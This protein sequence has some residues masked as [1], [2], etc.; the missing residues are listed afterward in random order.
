M[1]D[2]I[3]PRPIDWLLA[4]LAV[5]VFLVGLGLLTEYVALETD[6]RANQALTQRIEEARQ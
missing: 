6:T 4:A 2:N 5:A 1:R 3:T